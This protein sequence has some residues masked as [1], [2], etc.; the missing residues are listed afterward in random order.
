MARGSYFWYG[1][2]A[3]F[4]FASAWSV[5]PAVGAFSVAV[6]LMIIVHDLAGPYFV[7]GAAYGFPEPPP[8][9]LDAVT[10]VVAFGAVALFPVAIWRSSAHGELLWL[11]VL[12]PILLLISAMTVAP[13][14][15]GI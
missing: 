7:G 12:I 1:Y 5:W 4:A 6:F 15:M 14:A 9:A 2:A 8:T 13:I 3:F 10:T 11:F